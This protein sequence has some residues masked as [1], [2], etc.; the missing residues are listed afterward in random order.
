[1]NIS[2]ILRGYRACSRITLF[3]LFFTVLIPFALQAAKPALIDS[4][5]VSVGT[6]VS[7]KHDLPFWLWANQDSRVPQVGNSFFTRLRFGRKADDEKELDWMYGVDVTMRSNSA[8]PATRWTDAWGGLGYKNVQL[9]VGRKS[10][11]FPM[12]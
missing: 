3:A 6:V 11:I 5:N 10:E 2:L 12:C 4:V 1:M 9:S 8:E 7:S